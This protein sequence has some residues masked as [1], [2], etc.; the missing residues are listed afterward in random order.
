MLMQIAK[1]KYNFSLTGIVSKAWKPSYTECEGV[2]PEVL[3][4]WA[5]FIVFFFM[6]FNYSNSE[7]VD[8]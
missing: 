1:A 3:F 7:C 5:Q 2:C 4:I 6:N 8:I